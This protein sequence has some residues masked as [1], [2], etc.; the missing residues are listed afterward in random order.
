MRLVGRAVFWLWGFFSSREG[1]QRV[2]HR[3][4]RSAYPNFFFFE[5]ILQKEISECPFAVK[6]IC[7][8]VPLQPVFSFIWNWF[9]VR[10]FL[11]RFKCLRLAWAHTLCWVSTSTLLVRENRFV[12][13]LLKDVFHQGSWKDK[14]R[15]VVSWFS[16][17]QDASETHSKRG[18]TDPY[19]EGKN[20]RES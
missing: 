16:L 19:F 1:V 11:I 20:V 15:K 13:W 9:D 5:F 10:Y 2:W 12:E 4:L 7:L 18:E 6:Q 3:R 14:L 17:R 8:V